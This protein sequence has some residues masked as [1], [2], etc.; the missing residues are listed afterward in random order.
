[1][2]ENGSFETGTTGASYL[3]DGWS[4]SVTSS[5]EEYA[6]FDQA[7]GE[8]VLGVELF[9]SGW[10]AFLGAFVGDFVDLDVATFDP[11][12]QFWED[13]ENRWGTGTTFILSN[14]PMDPAR[15]D[16]LTELFEDF[17]LWPTEVDLSPTMV[18]ALFSAA[19]SD[20]FEDGWGFPLIAL[21]ASSPTFSDGPSSASTS[22][23]FESQAADLQVVPLPATDE[24]E[25]GA[26]HG[27]VNGWRVSLIA[28]N[29]QLPAG[30]VSGVLYYVRNVSLTRFNLSVT[31]AG[32][33]VD[34]TDTGSGELFIRY[35]PAEW[36]LL[37]PIPV[38]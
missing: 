31:P 34:F 16:A 13:F 2:I 9:A 26:A 38:L 1:M 11:S 37:E 17:D 18:S 25:T 12:P 3:P 20:N 15:F 8:D 23:R 27:L 24:L 36:W 6:E 19:T 5:E 28:T 14:P 22:E 7:V 29:G 32:A 21:T 35:N 30:F 33:V 10:G 4:L